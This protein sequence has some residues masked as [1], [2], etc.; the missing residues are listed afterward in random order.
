MQG[1][2]H[3]WHLGVVGEPCPDP[4]PGTQAGKAAPGAPAAALMPQAIPSPAPLP[5]GS[6]HTAPLPSPLGRHSP[7]QCF[8]GLRNAARPPVL[9]DPENPISSLGIPLRT[10]P[11]GSWPAGSQLPLCSQLSKG[12]KVLLPETGGS[13][14]QTQTVKSAGAVPSVSPQDRIPSHKPPGGPT[15]RVA[16]LDGNSV[17]KAVDVPVL[18]GTSKQTTRGDARSLNTASSQACPVQPWMRRPR[19]GAAS[20][21]VPE[22][23]DDS[24][25]VL[26]TNTGGSG[27]GRKSVL[28]NSCPP[29][30]QNGT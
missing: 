9:L 22:P 3:R 24:L 10:R 16:P 12:T 6:L 25:G 30:R 26:V 15:H 20:G 17:Q 27:D 18:R 7:A 11:G 13:E 8:P 23:A 29:G 5:S 14:G 2:A 1:Q 28:P 19:T 21:P 4:G